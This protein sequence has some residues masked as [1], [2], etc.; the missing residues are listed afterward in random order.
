MSPE[1]LAAVVELDRDNATFWSRVQFEGE[2][3]QESG[4][5]YVARLPVRRTVVALI[6]GRQTGDEAEI[7]KLTVDRAFRRRGIGSSLLDYA[8]TR[9]EQS[10]VCHCYLEMRASNVPARKLYE[11]KGFVEIGTRKDYYGA[12]QEDAVLMKKTFGPEDTNQETR[13]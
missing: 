6:C 1:D 3:G 12:P 10:G 9:M 13:E 7:L 11:K 2:L 5:Q 8:Q 4:F